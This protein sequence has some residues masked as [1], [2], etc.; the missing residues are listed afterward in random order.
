MENT[1]AL[2]IESAVRKEVTMEKVRALSKAQLAKSGFD[3]H[4]YHFITEPGTFT[5]YL[6]LKVCGKRCLH[7]PGGGLSG[8]C[9]YSNWYRMCIDL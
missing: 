1:V 6:E 4:S 9:G 8:P 7:V 2:L 5:A 3:A